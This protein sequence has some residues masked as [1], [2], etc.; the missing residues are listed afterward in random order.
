MADKFLKIINGTIQEVEANHTNLAGVSANQH[1]NE[2]HA[3]RHQSGGADAI[4][5]D[6]L[7]VP[8]DN[9]DLDVS[10]SAHGLVP[11]ATGDGRYSLGAAG[12]WRRNNFLCF[13]LGADQFNPAI[14]STYYLGDKWGRPPTTTQYKFPYLNVKTGKIR[15]VRLSIDI[16]GTLASQQYVSFYINIDGSASLITTAYMNETPLTLAKTDFDLTINT[17]ARVEIKMVCPNWTTAPT[18]VN[19]SAS[20][21]LE[22]S[23]IG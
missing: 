17:G 21:L 20:V 3:S 18:S 10:S 12:L 22:Y 8:D 15:E 14:N 23:G 9:T 7:A 11:K 4:K 13:Q 19:I 2:D 6:D 5:L 1:H 16:S